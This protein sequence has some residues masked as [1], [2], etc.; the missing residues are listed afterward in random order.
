[1]KLAAHQ[2][3]S[4]DEAL[5]RNT[6]SELFLWKAFWEWEFNQRTPLMFYLAQIAREVHC[7]L[8]NKTERKQVNLEQFLMKFNFEEDPKQPKRKRRVRVV[9]ED[10]DEDEDFEEAVV[11][12]I[13][14]EKKKRDHAAL[15]AKMSWFGRLG[16]PMEMMK[17]GKKNSN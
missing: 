3:C 1:M 12:T 17:D 15:L 13:E 9:E 14:E 5:E 7:V 10:F 2:K 11:D 6:Q 8:M 4:L 16:I